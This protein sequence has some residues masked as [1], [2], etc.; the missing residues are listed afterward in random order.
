MPKLAAPPM[1]PVQMARTPNFSAKR[2][3]AD[4]FIKRCGLRR[5]YN[6]N[7][8]KLIRT[9]LDEID[10]Q[11]LRDNHPCYSCADRTEM[12]RYVNAS[13]LKATAIDFLEFG[14]F[15]GESISEWI[16]IN[17]DR[18]SRFYGFDSFEGLPENWRQGQDKGHFD[19]GG[20]IPQIDDDR[21]NF[22][23]GWFD[24]T[25]PKFSREFVPRNRLVLHLDADL[26]SSTLL[27]LI[28]F[29]PYMAKGSLLLFDEFYDRDHEFKA[30]QDYLRISKRNYRVLC[31]ID[32]Y[33]KLC[34]ELQ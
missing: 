5:L 28:Y 19:V 29:E 23:K 26:Y 24:K 2:R 13:I 12:Y 34:V 6:T 10:L 30:F 11:H 32:N 25:V 17:K 27:P 21:V 22:I 20:N 1:D 16:S 9:V 8:Q 15:R 7:L 33:G 31:Q 18:A 4:L 3:V 14:V